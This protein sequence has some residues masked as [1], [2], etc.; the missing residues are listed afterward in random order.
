MQQLLD[1]G[2]LL[3]L[4]MSAGSLCCG[5]ALGPCAAVLRELYQAPKQ[6][7]NYESCYGR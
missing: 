1:A 5:N 7:E 3:M 4:Q 2:L 6:P